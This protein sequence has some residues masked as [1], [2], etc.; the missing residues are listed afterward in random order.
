MMPASSSGA[1]TVPMTGRELEL[2]E[3]TSFIDGGGAERGGFRVLLGGAGS[4]KS[5]ML[6]ALAGSTDRRVLRVS[7]ARQLKAIGE[8][9]SSPRLV[10]IDDIDRLT[11]GD[12]AELLYAGRRLP[13]SVAVVA[14]A[15]MSLLAELSHAGIQLATLAALGS[16]AAGKVLDAVAESP[17]VDYVRTRVL[18]D[19]SGNPT[20]IV[21]YLTALDADQLAGR[22]RLPN[23]LPLSRSA[24]ERWLGSIGSGSAPELGLIAFIAPAR[25]VE[26]E[27]VAAV[28]G[29]QIDLD[30]WERAEIIRVGDDGVHF[31]APVL[32]S[33][34]AALLPQTDRVRTH[35]AISETFAASAVDRSAWHRALAASAPDDEVAER[36]T[37]AIPLF[38]RRGGDGAVAD[39]L[40]LSAELSSTHEIA[41]PRLV[42][43][44]E[45]AWQAGW[46]SRARALLH[47]AQPLPVDSETE[48]TAALV[49]GALALGGGDPRTA[50]E[51]LLRGARFAQV[52]HP[53]LA[54]DQ[55]AR[56]A[57][58]AVWEGRADVIDRVVRALPEDVDRTP[59]GRLVATMSTVVARMLRGDHAAA[60]E[61]RKQLR[62]TGPALTTPRE[63]IFASEAGGILGDD[64][65]AMSF[66]Q[67]ASRAMT[68]TSP[69]A[70]AA[71]ALELL[72]HVNVW[73]GRLE[74]AV[75]ASDA[76]LEL[77]ARLDERRDG[78][79]QLGMLAHIAALRGDEGEFVS[80]AGRAISAAGGEEPPT[81]TWARGRAALSRGDFDGARRALADMT[82]A[83][84]RHALVALYAVPDLVEAAAETGTWED[85]AVRL[86]EFHAWAA[87]GSPW[88]QA[89]E[90][91]LVALRAGGA[92]GIELLIEAVESP[93][94]TPRPFDDARTRL[95]LGRALRR[96]RRRA[97]AR[98][99][100]RSAAATFEHLGLDGWA[101]RANA[102][103]R[104]S[105][106]STRPAEADGWGSLT[107]QER[108][109]ASMVGEGMSNRS[110]AERLHLSARTIEYHLSKVYVKLGVSNRAQLARVVAEVGSSD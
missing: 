21:D 71:F 56:V 102:E 22:R 108:E 9:S 88:A 60:H 79:F 15:D 99:H 14:T 101:A 5:S 63:L 32:R 26:I 97:E 52:T 47:Q 13:A 68:A 109:I 37:R 2:W 62:A 90:P 98:E 93:P 31:V 36:L 34:A 106:E 80:L 41:S 6:T 8:S 96:A 86:E 55:L 30:R 16:D 70:D 28:L 87:N 10:L 46:R 49:E 45:A 53:S 76:G 77:A 48:A 20:A 25:A 103:L 74:A 17:V 51:R 7:T 78:P 33:A 91:R 23:P 65:A 64:D 100:L 95:V 85:T 83:H 40:E 92:E 58:A 42:R 12:R 38:R 39:A 81:V 4:G 44:A 57:G 94:L 35:A 73:Q 43:G 69:Q 27:S 84:P 89:V 3:L 29:L 61:L 59:Y 107:S 50:T 66:L 110:A 104:A 67:R 24:A 18:A 82:Q 54:L 11:A 72:A 1:Q 105:G 75:A 19:A